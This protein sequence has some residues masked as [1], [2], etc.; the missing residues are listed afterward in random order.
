MEKNH[1]DNLKQD[2]DGISKVVADKKAGIE[3]ERYRA[4][5]GGV[6]DAQISDPLGHSDATFIPGK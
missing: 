5:K 1:F 3:A 6:S 2:N 4:M